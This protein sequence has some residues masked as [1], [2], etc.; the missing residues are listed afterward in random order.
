[1]RHDDHA[2][3]ARQ[4]QELAGH[5]CLLFRGPLG[6]QMDVW[7]FERGGV[8]KSVTVSGWLGSS[9][10]D[11]LV[12]AA[13]AGEGVMRVSALASW[14]HVQSGR[15]VPVLSDWVAKDAP[16]VNVFFRPSLRRTPRVRMFVEFIADLM[17][18]L[19]ATAGNAP[20]IE[21]S[22]RP[23]WYGKRYARSSSSPR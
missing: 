12:D 8:E 16:P 6:T 14:Q 7:K 9:H 20:E 15:L 21:E 23:F 11:M 4:P 19:N 2:V 18:K 17:V 1:M 22:P 5:S 3:R 10:R 13:L